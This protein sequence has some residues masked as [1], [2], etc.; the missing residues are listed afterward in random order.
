MA[1]TGMGEACTAEELEEQGT[2]MASIWISESLTPHLPLVTF[3]LTYLPF[4]GRE[5]KAKHGTTPQ[6]VHMG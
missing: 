2:Y 1:T 4:N 5:A 3:S 6:Q